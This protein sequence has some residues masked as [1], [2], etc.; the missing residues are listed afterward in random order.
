[1]AVHKII[2]LA[3]GRTGD[4]LW[5]ATLDVRRAIEAEGHTVAF[6]FNNLEYEE[7]QAK[8]DADAEADLSAKLAALPFDPNDDAL[9]PIGDGRLSLLLVKVVG[10]EQTKIRVLNSNDFTEVVETSA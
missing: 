5:R 9:Y 7:A 4:D 8:S 10:D 6:L 3:E 2:L 1:M